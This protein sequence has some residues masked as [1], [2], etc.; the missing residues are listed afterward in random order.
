V[1]H[2]HAHTGHAGHNGHHHPHP[3]DAVRSA[4]EQQNHRTTGVS[5]LKDISIRI[6]AATARVV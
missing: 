1:A 3:V 5:V 2:K 4:S 6:G